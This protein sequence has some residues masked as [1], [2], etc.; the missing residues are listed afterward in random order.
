LAINVFAQ[1][2]D[3]QQQGGGGDDQLL[4]GSGGGGG[5][6]SVGN[7]ASEDYMDD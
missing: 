7:S 2:P 4:R 1:M 3:E 6:V 5:G